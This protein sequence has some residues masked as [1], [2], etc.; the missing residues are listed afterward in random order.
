MMYHSFF[1]F[2]MVLLVGHT[3]IHRRKHRKDISLKE[4]NKYFEKIKY[5]SKERKRNAR[6]YIFENVDHCDKRHN[7]NVTRS[8]V[9]KKTDKK[10]KWFNEHPDNFNRHHYNLHW[11][12]QTW[13]PENVLPVILVCSKLRD[14]ESKNRQRCCN[15]NIS[16]YI[17][18]KR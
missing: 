12:R 16:C 10:R 8:H 3:K 2:V 13:H 9:R 15:C 5:K 1:T 11:Q 7:Y 18:T 4:C 14:K 17:N 6:D